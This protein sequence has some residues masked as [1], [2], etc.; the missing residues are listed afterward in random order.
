MF[1]RRISLVTI[2]IIIILNL[3][4]KYLKW[5]IV[6]CKHTD[7]IHKSIKTDLFKEDQLHTAAIC[8]SIIEQRRSGKIWLF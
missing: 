1:E 5:A 7:G 3:R 2:H 8:F 6:M 4:G